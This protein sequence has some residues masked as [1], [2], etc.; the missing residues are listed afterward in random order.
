MAEG[1]GLFSQTEEVQKER[2]KS[3]ATLVCKWKVV[4]FEPYSKYN[5]FLFLLRRLGTSFHLKKPVF[6]SCEGD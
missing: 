3:T 2:N 5:A 1:G 6:R 4:L